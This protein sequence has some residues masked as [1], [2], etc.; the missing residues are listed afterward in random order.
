[1]IQFASS[2]KSFWSCAKGCSLALVSFSR[3][4]TNSLVISEANIFPVWA[5]HVWPV[6]SY[7]V[8]LN[9]QIKSMI[10]KIWLLDFNKGSST[11]N[12]TIRALNT[13]DNCFWVSAPSTIENSYHSIEQ[14]ATIRRMKRI[15][16]K[17][18]AITSR[19]KKDAPIFDLLVSLLAVSA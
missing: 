2:R 4:R 7:L 9:V 18:M 19:S 12:Q 10:F 15:D 3:K 14:N 5:K 6:S 1:M 8:K 11:T 13:V 17:T 16:W